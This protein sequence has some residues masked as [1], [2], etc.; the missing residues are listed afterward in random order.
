ME[1]RRIAMTPLLFDP[2]QA[3]SDSWPPGNAVERRYIEAMARGGITRLIGNVRTRWLALRAGN[4]VFPMTVNDGEMND[5][6]V[7]L[8][9]SAYILYALQELD[10]VDVGWTKPFLRLLIKGAD[11]LLRAADINRIV[12]VDNWLLSTNLHGDWD[13]QDIGTIRRHLVSAYPAH[14]I[15]IRSVDPWSSPA[16]LAAAKRDGWRLLPSR[17][18]WVTE[19]LHLNW[20]KRNS[21]GNDRRQLRKSGL[22][23]ERLET[24]RPGDSKRIAELYYMLYVGKYSPLNPVFSPDWIEMTHR[25]GMLE[26]QVARD[27]EGVIQAVSGSFIRGRVLTPPVVGYDTTK[28]PADGLYRIASYF[29]SQTCAERGL[30][31]NGSAGAA[32]FKRNRGA[33]GVIEYTVAYVAHLPF[34]RRVILRFLEFIL[35]AA[36]V[37][38]MKWKQL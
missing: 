34:R 31:L 6:Y 3:P 33:S 8:P 1:W 10:L 27:S 13:G 5:S 18:I 4:R 14:I 37:P 16:L 21:T 32:D 28:P 2:L 26:Y 36:A 30:R 35:S 19:D 17:Q 20:A 22:S 11:R 24:L 38:I 29:F 23:I 9:H 25:S 15:A 7:C 12:H